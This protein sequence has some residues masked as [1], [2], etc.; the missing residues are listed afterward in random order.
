MP[1][2]LDETYVGS[3]GYYCPAP[4]E[5]VGEYDRV[6]VSFSDTM[7]FEFE[8]IATDDGR[9][10]VRRIDELDDDREVSGSG[11]KDV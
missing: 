8:I 2:E 1:S 11:G 7:E 3:D 5:F 6:K 10:E 4:E 9:V